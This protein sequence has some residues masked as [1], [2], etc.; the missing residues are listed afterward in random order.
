MITLC[1]NMYNLQRHID[2]TVLSGNPNAIHLLE[3]NVDKINWRELSRNPNAIHI[4]K[5]NL[6]KVS[7]IDLSYNP[8]A[9]HLLEQNVNK[10]KRASK[11]DKRKNKINWYGLSLNPNAIHLLEQ[12][13]D[14]IDWYQLSRNP[15]AIHLLEQHLDKVDWHYLSGNPNPE[16]IRLMAPLNHEQMRIDNKEFF[17]EL[18][19]FVCHPNWQMKCA[20]RLNMDLD[21]YQYLL[22]E[23]N[24]F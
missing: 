16:V 12:N 21:E 7:W 14:K 13:I 18:V 22:M 19:Q 2:W 4:L 24:V 6:D 1:K 10:N 5:Q 3:Q 15:N 11:K 23:C 20:S 8:N 17:Q 9:I